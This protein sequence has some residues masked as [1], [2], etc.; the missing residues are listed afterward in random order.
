MVVWDY[1]LIELF[2]KG[3]PCMWPLLAC[4]I[5]GAAVILDR[6]FVA[7]QSLVS[8]ERFVEGLSDQLK[9]GR[10]ESAEREMKQSRSPLARVALVYLDHR[11]DPPTIR[12]K[13]VEREASQQVAWLERRMNWLGMIASISTLLGLLGTVTGLVTAFHEIELNSGRVNP[14]D[15]ASGI[16]EALITTVFGLLIAIPCLAAYHLLDHRAGRMALQIQWVVHYLDEW[17]HRS[18]AVASTPAEAP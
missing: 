14:G 13:I 18:Q 1:S 7:L 4:S 15:L 8:F 12:E 2:H 16:W 10:F 6:T 9:A 11:F 17:L 5:L 3:G